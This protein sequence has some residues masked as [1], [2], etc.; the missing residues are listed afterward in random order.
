MDA[1]RLT[2]PI[3]VLA[4]MLAG[5]GEAL[6]WGASGH[7]MVSQVGMENVPAELPAFLRAPGMAEDV[8]ELGREP[9]RLRGAGEVADARNGP[10][11]YVDL[12][13][14]GRAM[15]GVAI[16]PLP[17]T[18]RDFETK[19]LAKGQKPDVVG[20]LPYSIIE[21]WQRL[22]LDFAYWRVLV[23][24]EKLAARPEDRA[25]LAGDRRRREMQIVRDLGWWSHF[26]GDGSQPLHISVHANGWGNYPNPNNYSTA[27]LHAAFE[28]AFVRGNIGLADL[29]A[30]VRPYADCGCEIEE[31][32]VRYLK[33]T[34]AQVIPLYE[35]EKTGAFTPG[36][37]AGKAFVAQRLAD[38]ASELRDMIVDAWRASA[39]MEVGY[40]RVAVKDIES[41]KVDA[42]PVLMG[43]D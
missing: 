21:G 40:P 3:A 27:K 15:G 37:A 43:D 9:D 19:L 18:Q 5:A 7:R 16:D 25:W 24:A 38:G 6:G 11:H 30:L 34:H 22:R 1:W 2:L 4:C 33:A 12:E 23:A 36:N 20:S 39:G 17:V 35:L 42:M 26:V 41:G 8:G 28:G 31:R 32:T 14:D 29:R 13:D 10:T